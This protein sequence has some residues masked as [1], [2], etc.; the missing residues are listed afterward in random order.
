M[1]I[2]AQTA[3]LPRQWANGK[4]TDARYRIH[5]SNSAHGPTLGGPICPS[6]VAPEQ[7][8]ESWESSPHTPTDCACMAGASRHRI[9]PRRAL[10][11][12]AVGDGRF[13]EVS[14]AHLTVLFLDEVREFVGIWVAA[15]LALK[16]VAITVVDRWASGSSSC[17]ARRRALTEL[18]CESCSIS[19]ISNPC[20]SASH[21]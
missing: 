4:Q 21:S 3:A 2:R 13:R 15:H 10:C 19:P 9:T 14:A 20:S 16:F 5:R 12:S 18:L 17:R 6:P 11:R 1:S 8:V 7:G